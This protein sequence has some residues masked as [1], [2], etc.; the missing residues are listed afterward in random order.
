[1]ATVALL[2]VIVAPIAVK[3][4][5]PVQVFVNGPPADGPVEVAVKLALPPTQMV[6][7]LFA[8]EQLGG[9][10]TVALNCALAETCREQSPSSEVPLS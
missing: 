8:I 10:T 7:E 9:P 6:C 4:F 5:G 1:M 3:P 2:I